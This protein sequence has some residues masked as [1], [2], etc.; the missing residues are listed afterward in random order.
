MKKSSLWERWMLFTWRS[1]QILWKSHEVTERI[2]VSEATRRIFTKRLNSWSFC[3]ESQSIRESARTTVNR[4]FSWFLESVSSFISWSLQQSSSWN[5]ETSLDKKKDKNHT[6]QQSHI[7]STNNHS[8]SISKFSIFRFVTFSALSR[9]LF[10]A[11]RFVCLSVCLLQRHSMS[12]LQRLV[13]LFQWRLMNE[14]VHRSQWDRYNDFKSACVRFFTSFAININGKWIY[15]IQRYESK[16]HDE[17]SREHRVNWFAI[18]SNKFVFFATLCQSSMRQHSVLFHNLQSI[19]TD[20]LIRTRKAQ[21][22]EVW[23]SICLRNRYRF[24]AFAFVFALFWNIDR[25]IILI[26]R[27]LR[28]QDSQQDFHSRRIYLFFFFSHV[29]CFRIYLFTFIAFAMEFSALIM[30]RQIFESSSTNFFAMS[31]DRRNK[32]V[33]SRRSLKKKKE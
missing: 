8:K 13:S 7:K 17:K 12:S 28:D 30:I 1:I 20:R 23:N 3:F 10:V 19:R 6:Q 18:Q 16:W 25:F 14:F 31:I 2:F 29:F 15:Y 32:L 4:R 26:C 27:Y 33:A 9:S 5:V 21:I 11:F 24:A 22:R